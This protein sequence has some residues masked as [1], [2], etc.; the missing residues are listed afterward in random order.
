MEMNLSPAMTPAQA[1]ATGWR[2][3]TQGTQ[4]RTG[5]TSGFEGLVGG[6]RIAGGSNPC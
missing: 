6:L 2:G 5:G 1:A 4:I 3:T